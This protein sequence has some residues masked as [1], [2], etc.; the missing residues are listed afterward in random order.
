M[1][2]VRC[3][4]RCGVA[5]GERV[6]GAA[7]L[8]FGDMRHRQQRDV[9]NLFIVGCLAAF[10]PAQSLTLINATYFHYNLKLKIDFVYGFSKSYFYRGIDTYMKG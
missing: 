3:C 2:A 5:G 4:R 9:S 8:V 6:P 7:R 1:R 10:G